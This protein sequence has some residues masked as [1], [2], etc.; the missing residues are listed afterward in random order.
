VTFPGPPELGRGAVVLPGA[1]SPPCLAT[2]PRIRLDDGVLVSPTA[3]IRTL[4]E[5]WARRTPVVVELGVDAS[6]LERPQT[7]GAAVWSLPPDFELA[8]ERLGF[9]VWANNWD[10]RGPEPVWWRSRK[11]A[12]LGAVE[13]GP[14]DVVLPD[15]RAV[16]CDGGPRG[17]V[18]VPE[19]IVHRE[20]IE[21]G[22]LTTAG[23]DWPQPRAELA[24]D[25][26]EAV[27]HCSGPAR[28]IAP[29]GSGKTRVLTERLH[30]LIADRGVE[31]EIVT[32]VAYNRK[33]AEELRNRTAAF[34]PHVRT[35]HSLGLSI[36][37]AAAPRTV[38]EERDVRRILDGLVDVRHRRNQDVLA[39]FVEALAEVRNALR[40]PEDVEDERDD[41][42]GFAEV[43]DR[44]RR[45]LAGNGAVDFDEQVYSAIELMLT[46]ADLRRRTQQRCRHMLVDEFQDLTPAH[47]LLLRLCAAPA[48]QVFGVGDD[49]QVI[50]GHAGADPRFLLDFADLFPGAQSHALEVN[51][52]CPPQVVAAAVSLLGHNRL[53]VPKNIRADLAKPGPAGEETA[54]GEVVAVRRCAGIDLAVSAAD[55]IQE[56]LDRGIPPGEIA[57][58]A[59]VNAA[60]IPVQAALFERGV[61]FLSTLGGE[62]LGRTGLRT[63]LAYL[64]IAVHP[65]R[66][67]RS[68]LLETIRRPSRRMKRETL[69]RI[70]RRRG[71]SLDDLAGVRC[72]N[73]VDEERLADYVE[74]LRSLGRLAALGDVAAVVA[75]I[76]DEIGLGGAMSVLDS[77]RSG[78]DRSTHSD[79]LDSLEGA[80]ALHRDPST[81]AAWLASVL[82]AAQADPGQGVTLSS[83]H[84]V[85]GREWPH[86]VI[87]GAHEGLMPHRLAIGSAA[88]EEERRVFHV[89]L[90]R[91]REDVLVLADSSRAAPFVDEMEGRTPPRR[92]RPAPPA[93]ARIPA[94]GQVDVPD[95][96][97]LTPADSNLFEALRAWRLERCRADGV[98]PYV[99]CHDRSL[100][101]IASSRPT[102][103]QALA[104]CPGIGPNKLDRYGDEILSVVEDASGNG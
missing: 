102:T 7:T 47:L 41:V 103:V 68:D 92:E 88:E 37:Q 5:A 48:Y 42:P 3:A 12:R 87:V 39:P 64:R 27:A 17:P 104:A 84:R 62:T 23:P 90:T 57:V 77:S 31:R 4:A 89:A 50:Y 69:D 100:R 63:A 9:L 67:D 71:W 18:A 38:L 97:D 101:A 15:G 19:P 51:Y 45:I 35:I 82:G 33:A 22:R 14:C 74:E 54:R 96:E 26:R 58:L 28:V 32:A 72:E 56:H 36:C 61:P 78:A 40:D 46:D 65:E 8:R 86:V 52:R 30:H 75:A 10:L 24:P 16:W 99:V 43:F 2:A 34:S 94:R 95:A 79:D 98:P 85:K 76:R 29:A 83:I 1:E 91:C 44:Y 25:Q 59:R 66:I 53:R 49:D 20:S 55:W 11:A 60:L 21:L 13:G 81:F 70:G 73:T 6:E 80:A 93:P